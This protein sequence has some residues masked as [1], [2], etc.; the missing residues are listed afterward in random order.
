MCDNVK[1]GSPMFAICECE[2]AS[3]LLAD[4]IEAHNKALEQYNLEYIEYQKKR[5][6]WETDQRNW[7][8]KRDD[9]K[10]GLG[11]YDHYAGCGTCGSNPGCPGGWRWERNANGC[12]FWNLGCEQVCR[13]TNEQIERDMAEWYSQNPQPIEPKF[14]KQSPQFQS[15]DQI[16]C[17]AQLF[18]NITAQSAN[19]D[20]IRQQC[21]DK[22]KKDL[23]T[24]KKLLTPETKKEDT[25][26]SFGSGSQLVYGILISLFFIIVS[27]SFISILFFTLRSKRPQ[28]DS[29][30]SRSML[31]RPR[32][33]LR[34]PMGRPGPRP[35]GPGPGQTGPGQTGPGQTGP[36]QTGPG[37]TGPGPSVRRPPPG[38]RLRP[39]PSAPGP[40][41]GGPRPRPGI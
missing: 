2:R 20:N 40:R 17:C 35:K 11:N 37:Q 34:V 23:E 12:G 4:K 18:Q 25:G 22:I 1:S 32:P 3:K 14:D 13:R 27:V 26:S 29:G 31:P 30:G 21:N 7:E 19:F 16:T 28:K 36:G 24:A 8:S 15:N 10:R 9:R 5:S 39:L 38:M 41:P 33:R 6:Q